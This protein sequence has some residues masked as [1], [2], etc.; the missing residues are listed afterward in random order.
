MDHKSLSYMELE[1]LK[2]ACTD[3]TYKEIALQLNL[4]PKTIDGIRD[5]LFDRFD[6]KS[7]VGLAIYAVKNGIM[8]I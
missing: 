7:M 8:N 5:Q 2:L 6:V 3:M 4:S 1:F